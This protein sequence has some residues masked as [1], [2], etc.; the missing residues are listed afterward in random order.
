NEVYEQIERCSARYKLLLI[1]ACRSDPF[2]QAVVPRGLQVTLESVP[3]P[4]DLPLPKGMAALFSCSP[5]EVAF[6]NKDLNHGILF[7]HLLE[8]LKGKA[9]LDSDGEITLNELAAYTSKETRKYAQVELRTIQ[10]P[11]LKGEFSDWPVRKLDDAS[12]FQMGCDLLAK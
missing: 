3:R 1:D 2:N 7:Y 5:G 9:D 11:G 6:E 8:G 10:T 12:Y 4:Q